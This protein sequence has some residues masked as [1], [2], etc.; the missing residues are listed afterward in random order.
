MNQDEVFFNQEGDKWFQ[1]NQASLTQEN[2]SDWVNYVLN[3]LNDTNTIQNVLELGCSNGWRLNQLSQTFKTG[4]FFGIDA[5]EQA[6]K[7]GQKRYPNLNLTRGLLSEVTLQDQFDLVIVNFVLHWLDRQ[8][9]AKSIAEIDR[10]TK[11]EGFLIIGD[12]LPDFQQKKH[13]HHCQDQEI[14]TY[15]QDY[16]KIFTS[17][18]IYS[19]ITRISF[20]HDNYSSNL[21]FCESNHRGT[22]VLMKKSLTKFYPI[23]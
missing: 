6:I 20:N 18:G 17:L 22:I 7:D 15:K 19:E 4:Q 5:S 3:W 14:Y 16:A 9:L 1:R 23:V 2:K 13:Y 21:E 12:F 10:M 8:S 11:D